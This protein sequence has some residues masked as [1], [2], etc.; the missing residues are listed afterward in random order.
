MLQRALVPVLALVCV[1]FGGRLAAAETPLLAASELVPMLKAGGYVLYFRHAATDRSRE[2]AHPVKFDDCTN[3]RVLSAAGQTQATE[4][5]QAMRRL[6]I[7]VGDIA[8][9]PYCRCRNTAELAF[10]RYRVDENLYFAMTAGPQERRRISTALRSM[11]SRPPAGGRNDV[12]VS[13]T[14]NLREAA[15]IWPKPEGV[16]WVIKPDGKGA[17]TA[18]GKID[19]GEWRSLH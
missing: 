4:I 9:S 8:S 11:L 10:G 6:E 1:L 13:H 12:I 3:Q 15:G 16:V 2:D 7:P 18:L 5:G 17:F 19:P 14:A